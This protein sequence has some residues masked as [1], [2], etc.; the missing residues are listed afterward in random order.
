M[1][2][3]DLLLFADTPSLMDGLKRQLKNIFDV[4]DLGEPSKIVGIEITRDRPNRSIRISQSKYIETILIKHGLQSSNSVGMPL[5]PAI[6]VLEKEDTDQDGNRSNGYAS[7]IGS[8]MYLAVAMRPDLAYTIQR[9][10]SFTANPGLKHWIAVKR[11]LRYL[12]GTRNLGIKYQG[13]KVPDKTQIRFI[14]WTDADFAND[15]RD[16][17]S[18]SGYVFKL[19]NG[20]ITWSSKK[21]NA[22][23]LSSTEAEYTAMAHATREAVWLRNLFEELYLPQSL[24][25]ILYGDNMSALAIARDPQYHARSKHFDIKN[26]YI[27]NKIRDQ[28]IK[29][30]YC[31]TE[32]MIADI[33]TKPLHKPKH[34]KFTTDLGMFSA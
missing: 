4:T 26:H 14:G 6:I 18:I 10:S 33:L 9:L 29:D 16:R 28:T 12:A 23:S 5:D 15:P 1:W 24:P 20:A 17:I 2:V 13:D 19:G 22:V 8:L 3:D 21:Q 27:R 7:L 30:I 32:D 11:V 34:W 25:T 31:P